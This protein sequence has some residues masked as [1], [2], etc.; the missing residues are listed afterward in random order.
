VSFLVDGTVDSLEEE[1]G[2][3]GFFGWFGDVP[4]AVGIVGSFDDWVVG[5]FFVENLEYV[6]F[7]ECSGFAD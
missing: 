1:V 3:A 7:G 4:V 6:V 5:S 2:G